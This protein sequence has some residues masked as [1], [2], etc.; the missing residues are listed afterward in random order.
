MTIRLI[1]VRASSACTISYGA[2][3]ISAKVICLSFSTSKLMKL[4][5]NTK[6]SL[7]PVTSDDWVVSKML[8]IIR[9]D[10]ASDV[11]VGVGFLL[12]ISSVV[13]WPH[14]ASISIPTV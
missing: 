6:S 8:W 1:N 7:S 4:L 13:S 12:F 5:S 9:F 3:S 10:S 2:F 14:P 11:E